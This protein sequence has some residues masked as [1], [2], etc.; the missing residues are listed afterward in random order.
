[1]ERFYHNSQ[2]QVVMNSLQ[3]SFSGQQAQT[4]YQSRKQA[5]IGGKAIN[6]GV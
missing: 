4:T 1:M 5:G 6:C 3:L 2:G